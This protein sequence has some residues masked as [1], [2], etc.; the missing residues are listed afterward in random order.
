[1]DGSMGLSLAGPNGEK[2]LVTTRVVSIE[3]HRSIEM[4]ATDL[5]FV[6]FLPDELL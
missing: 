6:A 3:G 5:R 2:G 1:M 4:V